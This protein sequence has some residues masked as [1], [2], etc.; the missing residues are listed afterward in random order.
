M[1]KFG[2]HQSHSAHTSFLK[3]KGKLIICLIIYVEDMVIT[4]N[5]KDE[6]KRLKNKLF[7]E[8]EMKDLGRLKYFLGIKV[9]R[10]KWG[11]LYCKLVE[12]PMVVNHGLQTK[13]DGEATNQEQYQKLVGKQNYLSHTRP[14]IAYAAG[15]V[16]RFMHRAQVQRIEAILRI[17]RYLIGSSEKGI[18]FRKNQDFKL[19]HISMLI[20]Q[21]IETTGNRHVD[22]LQWL[23][24]IL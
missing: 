15:V 9:L 14:H 6:I 23:K 5:D 21:E 20:G 16:S 24:G 8:L 4:G 12:T 11:M 10:S 17:I 22:I 13:E 19:K 18:M 3:K 2:Y 1:K 7:K